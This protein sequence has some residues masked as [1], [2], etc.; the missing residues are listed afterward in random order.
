[1]AVKNNIGFGFVIAVINDSLKYTLYSFLLV[2]VF[3]SKF[4]V[5]L[6]LSSLYPIYAKYIAPIILRNVNNSSDDFISKPSPR[7]DALES[8]IR[9]N[10]FAAFETN[11]T[12]KSPLIEFSIANST[13]GPGLAI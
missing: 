7:I 8:T 13:A 11:T 4:N 3:I 6:F 2:V 9:P 5:E 12:L 10:I 1:M